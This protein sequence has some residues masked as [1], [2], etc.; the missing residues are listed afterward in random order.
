M[1]SARNWQIDNA[2]NE[3]GIIGKLDIVLELLHENDYWIGKSWP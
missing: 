2:V 3:K 1:G